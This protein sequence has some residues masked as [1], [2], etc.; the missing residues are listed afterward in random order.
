M[1]IHCSINH[2]TIIHGK[3]ISLNKMFCIYLFIEADYL[4]QS[5]SIITTI[6]Y[7]YH[8]CTIL[9]SYFQVSKSSNAC[10]L[11]KLQYSYE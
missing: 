4:T 6:Y 3:S 7:I 9:P 10:F 8:L 11:Y 5:V 2:Y 1:H